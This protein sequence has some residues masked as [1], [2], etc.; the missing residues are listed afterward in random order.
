MATSSRAVGQVGPDDDDDVD[1]ASDDESGDSPIEAADNDAPLSSARHSVI[2]DVDSIAAMTVNALQI[3]DTSA[4]RRRQQRQRKKRTSAQVRRIMGW[5]PAPAIERTIASEQA[6]VES[7]RDT[8]FQSKSAELQQLVARLNGRAKVN[9]DDG[10]DD[11]DDDIRGHIARDPADDQ[12]EARRGSGQIPLASSKNNQNTD[13]LLEL[14]RTV[15]ALE[16]HVTAVERA[17]RGEHVYSSASTVQFS[18]PSAGAFNFSPGTAVPTS[19]GSEPP[20][21]NMP[22]AEVH[23]VFSRKLVDLYDSVDAIHVPDDDKTERDRFLERHR[24]AM[25]GHAS[26]RVLQAT[27]RMYRCRRKFLKWRQRRRRKLAGALHAWRHLRQLE[28]FGRRNACRRVFRE[29]ADEVECALKLRMIELRLLQ[30]SST[31]VATVSNLV[32]NLFLT[33]TD[34]FTTPPLYRKG[35]DY[36]YVFVN[37]AFAAVQDK[38]KDAVAVGRIAAI[39]A[40]M[41]AARE[42][43]AKQFVH[44]LFLKWKAYHEQHKRTSVNAQLSLR[45]AMRIAFLRRPKWLGER[46]QVVFEM[47]ARY[48]LFQKHKRACMPV[49]RF[50]TP[51]AQWDLWVAE[52]KAR[53][54]RK[55]EAQAR[56]PLMWMTRYYRLLRAYCNLSKSK[57]A[58]NRRARAYCSRRHLGIVFAKWRTLTLLNLETR[59]SIK[60]ALYA[61][62]TYTAMRADCRVPKRKIQLRTRDARVHKAWEGWKETKSRRS[63]LSLDRRMRLLQPSMYPRALTALYHWANIT[64]RE[65]KAHLF[66][67]WASRVYRRKALVKLW[68]EATRLH[69]RVLLQATFTA[70]RRHL[71]GTSAADQHLSAD[72][73]A[74]D[75]LLESAL[76]F[77]FLSDA[78]D[79]S[80]GDTS[81]D[82][83]LSELHAF[84]VLVRNGQAAEMEALLL[85]HP[86]LASAREPVLGNNALHVAAQGPPKHMTWTA[87]RHVL[88]L[89]VQAGASPFARNLVGD[90]ALSLVSDPEMRHYLRATGYGFHALSRTACNTSMIDTRVLWHLLLRLGIEYR[91]GDR[92]FGDPDVGTWHTVDVTRPLPSTKWDPPPNE[93]RRRPFLY[94]LANKLL[95]RPVVEA[96]E[97]NA[98]GLLQEWYLAMHHQLLRDREILPDSCTLPCFEM[99]D[100][101]VDVCP[102]HAIMPAFHSSFSY[103]RDLARTTEHNLRVDLVGPL[104]GKRPPLDAIADQVE[105]LAV[106]ARAAEA[107][108]LQ[109]E[110]NNASLLPLYG[111]KCYGSVTEELQGVDSNLLDVMLCIYF[112]LQQVRMLDK[113]S[114]KLPAFIALQSAI[115]TETALLQRLDRAVDDHSRDVKKACTATAAAKKKL[116]LYQNAYTSLFT[117]IKQAPL[118]SGDAVEKLIATR[119][120]KQETAQTRLET[121][122][123]IYRDL[124]NEQRTW[125]KDEFAILD[126][127]LVI[128]T[129]TMDTLSVTIHTVDARRRA[130]LDEITQR[131]PDDR[132]GRR[133]IKTTAKK[134]LLQLHVLHQTHAACE[135]LL[136]HDV[137]G[138]VRPPSALAP[139]A[140]VT[141]SSVDDVASLTTVSPL[142]SEALQHH[143][144]TRV[145]PPNCAIAESVLVQ[146]YKRSMMLLFAE[147]RRIIASDVERQ[148]ADAAK[149]R[150]VFFEASPVAAMPHETATPTDVDRMDRTRRETR[151]INTPTF[152]RRTKAEARP[153]RKRLELQKAR[154]SMVSRA[155]ASDATSSHDTES[156]DADNDRLPTRLGTSVSDALLG[157]PRTIEGMQYTFGNFASRA[158]YDKG[159]S[160]AAL[161]TTATDQVDDDAIESIWRSHGEIASL[162]AATLALKTRVFESQ[163]NTVKVT[164]TMTHP[165][166]ARSNS[167]VGRRRS[168]E[169]KH[170]SSLIEEV[171]EAPEVELPAVIDVVAPDRVEATATMTLVAPPKSPESARLTA[172]ASLP[173]RVPTPRDALND[174]EQT[175]T[176]SARSNTTDDDN[177]EEEP[178]RTPLMLRIGMPPMTPPA[179]RVSISAELGLTSSD[180]L[181]NLESFA[182]F[183]QT[184]LHK[185]QPLKPASSVERPERPTLGSSLSTP[186]LDVSA[187]LSSSSSR[188]EPRM[189]L[190][191]ELVQRDD[192][193]V[194]RH[195]PKRRW[196]TKRSVPRHLPALETSFS[197]DGRAFAALHQAPTSL[198][199]PRSPPRC[200]PA[201]SSTD[202]SNNNNNNEDDNNEDDKGN[203]DADEHRTHLARIELLYNP[204]N[205]PG[206]APL[207]MDQPKYTVKTLREHRPFNGPPVAD[208]APVLPTLSNVVLCGSQLLPPTLAPT[209]LFPSVAAETLLQ[210]TMT[211]DDKAKVW[212]AFTAKPLPSAI[213]A[214]YAELYPGTYLT[215]TP[216]RRDA[217]KIPSSMSMPELPRPSKGGVA[218]A[219]AP[220]LLGRKSAEICFWQ[221]VEGFKSIRDESIHGLVLAPAKVRRKRRSVEI[222]HEFLTP[223]SPQALHWILL[224]YPD[225]IATIEQLVQGETVPATTFNE[226]QRAVERRLAMAHAPNPLDDNISA[227]L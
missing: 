119:M 98:P 216:L 144:P 134:L 165:T 207:S 5:Y 28:G 44:T 92:A 103:G 52:Y 145:V 25:R 210:E 47:W 219:L 176:L 156:Y 15:T 89:L 151:L 37:E 128:Q 75:A 193:I 148:D 1:L 55:L 139:T 159:P 147:E 178:P 123:T 199:A 215:A 8:I 220:S 45:R 54:L 161:E 77:M 167:R 203:G 158:F 177:G 108:L 4:A 61:W 194:K 126:A 39:R 157:E 85:E 127:M 80:L 101:C 180:L 83:G 114:E 11:D 140:V 138:R 201:P 48:T 56:S 43:V 72:P 9:D 208:A 100:F 137:G 41:R 172:P 125:T 35:P 13:Q 66:H 196:R 106:L 27:F 57:K 79:S 29:W 87:H 67:R 20:T 84:Q 191:H 129:A 60:K 221:A 51:L 182:F 222:A 30:Q 99:P 68:T 181:A 163:T 223:Q 131:R 113:A 19:L 149:K 160:T 218:S 53:Q 6:K 173:L 154:I 117:T 146:A 88:R 10:D 86:R 59:G 2:S 152:R 174:G 187:P 93:L 104:L 169:A 124:L 7:L 78:F 22:P 63:V 16:R 120:Q 91:R 217:I 3:P 213:Q 185:Q 82:V 141:T 70:W 96:A 38:S 135:L 209:S 111:V 211:K 212:A 23:R 12:P 42:T 118:S 166:L 81:S 62:Q 162:S 183:S 170:S 200:I 115:P 33:T 109:V 94:I 171:A 74:I 205:D 143:L 58:E 65:T 226:L 17:Y 50:P 175:P 102:K 227:L 14:A 121:L 206:R 164:E 150:E 97:A 90:S 133:N 46:V 153:N 49:P 186:E 64:S 204:E 168:L 24:L 188:T 202:Q 18:L 179:P 112:K 110:R 116:A 95:Q 142:V 31:K 40:E 224:E 136:V 195:D 190:F 132:L 34:D 107:Q 73:V 214:A 105:K 69:G 192:S 76:P 36:S 21:P 198:P 225:V 71:A 130:L 197:L 32:K 26:A 155:A 189:R 122:Q 184:L